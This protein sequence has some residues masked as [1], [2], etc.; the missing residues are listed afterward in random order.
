VTIMTLK[1]TPF[2]VLA[3]GILMVSVAGPASAA[4]NADRANCIAI[5]ATLSS[6]RGISAQAHE[7]ALTDVRGNPSMVGYDARTNCPA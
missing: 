5:G 4:P 3:G 1:R 7:K 2:T 6:S